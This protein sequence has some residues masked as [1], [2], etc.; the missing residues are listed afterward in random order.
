[1]SLFLPRT[2]RLRLALALADGGWL[3]VAG[4][5]AHLVRFPAGVE[6]AAKLNELLSHPGLLAT[7]FVAMWATAVA[8]ELYEPVMLRRRREVAARVAIVAVMWGA[9]LA[10]A[11]YLVPGWRF[12]RGL[13]LITTTAWAVGAVAAR[14]AV[15]LWLRR[16]PRPRALVVGEAGAVEDICRKLHEHPAA[17]WEPVDGAGLTAAQVAEEARRR[18]AEL[19]VLA[20]IVSGA[21][22]LVA[23]LTALQ[24]SGVP[25]VVASELWAWL[26]GRLPVDELSPAAF[27][28]QPGFS[29]MH[30]ELFNRVT[31]VVD[32]VV[33]VA[34]LVVGLPVLLLAMVAVLAL[35]GRPVF[36]LQTRVGQFGRRFRVIKLRTMRPDAEENGPAFAVADDPRATRLGRIL[37]R[38][39]FDELPQLVNVIRGD[40]SLVG[41]RPERPEFVAELARTI[42]YYTFRL[43]VP[44][45]LTGWAQV[46]M[47]SAV[48]GDEHRR[49]LEYDLYFIRERSFGIYLLTLLRTAS[50]ALVG[51]RR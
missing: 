30:W 16:R 50:V 8:A 45:G 24:F 28:H 46:N 14:G 36:F 5:L 20:G 37:R 17:P 19:V 25:V 1:M 43:A 39:R 47:P 3:A 6:R 22:G 33:G 10:V 12:G 38:L 2:P 4:W 21:D 26:D 51:A 34:L 15:A 27:L 13:L 11:T 32:V 29:V 48:S 41:P 31:R 9:A 42:P 40:M 7:G 23:D 35:N 49:K 18:G 44:P